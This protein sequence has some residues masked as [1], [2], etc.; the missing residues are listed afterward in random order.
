MRPSRW[1]ALLIVGWLGLLAGGWYVL[2]RHQFTPGVSGQVPQQWPRASALPLDRQRPTLVLFTHRNCPCTRA[3]LQELES[4]LA[5]ASDPV[6]AF[7]VLLAFEGAASDRV[8][9]AIE[10]RARSLPQVEVRIDPDGVEA[11][12]FGVRTSGHVVLYGADGRLRF[13][14]GITDARGHAGDSI[15]QRAVLAC[16]KQEIPER[17]TAPVYGC[18][19]FAEDAETEAEDRQ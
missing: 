9:G 18:S 17:T 7:V 8:G 3:T 16:L 13:S 1:L 6:R 10:E 12:R 4:I 19:L 11:R 14:G 5:N 15:G 2:L